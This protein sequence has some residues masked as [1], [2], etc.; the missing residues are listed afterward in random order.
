ML[1]LNHKFLPFLLILFLEFLD[2]FPNL[3]L[4]YKIIL[5]LETAL[6]H[7]G[8]YLSKPG[9]K[10]LVPLSSGKIPRDLTR[11]EIL[12]NPEPINAG[13]LK[14]IQGLFDL[15]CFVR[16]PRAQCKNIIDARWVTTWKMV[17]GI[18]SIKCRLTARGFKDKMQ[19]LETYAGTTSRSGQRLVNLVAAQEEDFVLFSFDVSQ[20]FA[21][22]MTFKELSALTGTELRE[23]QF[24]IPKADL[25]ILRQIPAFKGYDPYK[26]CL[27]MIKPIY[28]LKDA[29]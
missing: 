8:W 25:E 12:A 2:F 15:G 17:D 26:E 3:K 13:K 6:V 1:L 5:L 20:A 10:G 9:T 28:G 16:C 23:V 27:N 11:E 19:E 24:D 18:L 22:G 4:S 14:E 29:P 21:K 7:D